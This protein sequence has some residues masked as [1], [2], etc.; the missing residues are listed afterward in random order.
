MT[1]LNSTDIKKDVYEPDMNYF[2]YTYV[3]CK[4]NVDISYWIFMY[5]PNNTMFLCALF[6]YSLT[7]CS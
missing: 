2:F 1:M 3:S 4:E 7:N 5:W 6:I